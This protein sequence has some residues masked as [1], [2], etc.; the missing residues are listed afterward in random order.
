VNYQIST[1]TVYITIGSG[2]D[3]LIAQYNSTSQTFGQ[4]LMILGESNTYGIAGIN[5]KL[6]LAITDSLLTFFVYKSYDFDSD[7]D[8]D[9]PTY[10][11][12][13]STLTMTLTIPTTYAYTSLSTIGS[14]PAGGTLNTAIGVIS[15]GTLPTL[16]TNNHAQ[17]VC[18][19]VIDIDTVIEDVIPVN[20]NYRFLDDFID[21]SLIFL[22]TAT[23][24]IFCLNTAS[25]FM[26]HTSYQNFWSL[27]NEF[28]LYQTLLLLNVYIPEELIRFW[29]DLSYSLFSFQFF[30]DIG[31]PNPIKQIDSDLE[32][33]QDKEIYRRIGL[34]SG[35]LFVN[36]AFLFMILVIIILIDL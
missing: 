3:T 19:I 8:D 4:T 25:I 28:Q 20:D 10:P 2:S 9:D 26:N 13:N 18:Y 24:M 32:F 12:T 11:L 36:E 22:W 27:L 5:N 34:S 35:S 21:Y 31:I 15:N 33:P 30:G 23:V 29:T 7:Y 14:D 1:S 16:T 17:T 6:Y